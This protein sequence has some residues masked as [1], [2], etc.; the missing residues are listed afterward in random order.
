MKPLNNQENLTRVSQTKIINCLSDNEWHRNKEIVKKSDL[1]APTVSKWLKRYEGNLV[2]KKIDLESGEYP[3]PVRY[4]LKP[5]GLV[6]TEKERKRIQSLVKTSLERGNQS[7]PYFFTMFYDLGIN[8]MAMLKE[9]INN[10]LDKEDIG[11]LVDFYIIEAYWTWFKLAYDSL[12][13]KTSQ[14]LDEVFDDL[15]DLAD[16][17]II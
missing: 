8:T 14:E 10:E 16:D 13:D 15:F 2:E 17:L 1:S 5:F 3:Y 7:K 6:L 12:K 9:S 11:Y 4:R